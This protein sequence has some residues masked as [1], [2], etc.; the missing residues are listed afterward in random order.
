MQGAWGL[1]M[2]LGR[3]DTHPTIWLELSPAV[4]WV[5]CISFEIWNNG[6]S[7]ETSGI[8]AGCLRG[9]YANCRGS[10]AMAD[11]RTEQHCQSGG[12]AEQ[13]MQ[14]IVSLL[15]CPHRLVPAGP[16]AV[17][18]SALWCW[19]LVSWGLA[20]LLSGISLWSGFCWNIY[21]SAMS[22]LHLSFSLL[23]S[24]KAWTWLSC[25]FLVFLIQYL[26]LGVELLIH[27]LN[28]SLEDAIANA[29]VLTVVKGG[30][31]KRHLR[32]NTE[33]S[34][35]W[36]TMPLVCIQAMIRAE[37]LKT[38]AQEV[39]LALAVAPIPLIKCLLFL[40]HLV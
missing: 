38:W 8:S 21:S 9:V 27:P 12:K 32:D 19:S 10:G 16:R 34:L 28:Y 26:L 25:L 29:A 1:L 30:L 33:R 7:C 24:I 4:S 31:S 14:L 3:E 37:L 2:D 39:V 35:F 13:V 5:W 11:V 18:T 17:V 23:L 40:L 36:V 6:G 20:S 22:W 15:V